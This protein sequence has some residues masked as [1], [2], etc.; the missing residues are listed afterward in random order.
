MKLKRNRRKKVSALDAKVD[1]LK[2]AL[3]SPKMTIRPIELLGSGAQ[4]HSDR[5]LTPT[6]FGRNGTWILGPK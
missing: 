6:A 3:R 5:P 1:F 2:N 4:N